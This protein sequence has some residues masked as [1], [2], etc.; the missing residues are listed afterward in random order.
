M[1]R[2]NQQRRAAKAK[3]R[4]RH[5]VPAPAY[6]GAGPGSAALPPP[7]NETEQ[8]RAETLEAIGHVATGRSAY[9]ESGIQRLVTRSREPGHA[10]VITREL[11]S[12]LRE[13]LR[14]AWM[15][16]WRPL[17][18]TR[19]V[20]RHLDA[21]HVPI[22]GDAMAGELGTYAA[23]TLAPDWPGQLRAID[24]RR[25]W[26]SD[27]DH[28]TARAAREGFEPVLRLA[29]AL[30]ALLTRLPRIEIIDPAPGTAPPPS[31]TATRGA[32][33]GEPLLERVRQLLA[34]AESTP[35]E[36][37]ADTFTTA[38]QSLMARHS[39]DAAMLAATTPHTDRPCARRVW[40]ERPYE[41]EKV[42]LLHVVAEANRCR[43]VWSS[44]L[45]FVTVVGHEVDQAAVDTLFTSLLLQG[46]RAMTHEGAASRSGAARTRGFRKSFLF[47]YAV[48]IGERLREATLA[49]TEAAMGQEAAAMAHQGAAPAPRPRGPG[50][51]GRSQAL[52]QVLSARSAEVDAAVDAMFPTTVARRSS[53]PSDLRGWEAGWRAA[54]TATLAGATERL[55]A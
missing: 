26:P 24:A 13:L 55:D 6:T 14:A 20:E 52:V 12:V 7:A 39:I 1:G 18:L 38:A 22:L 25:W 11:A 53:V 23:A 48:R 29:L 31:R 5:T 2:R 43:T 27:Q 28:V 45:G 50:G 41:R 47:S 46:T 8:V 21:R 33:A 34:K 15:A 40:I 44:G 3:E 19:H 54:E 9:A 51:S 32:P 4:R 30:A 17:D 49:E 42:R 10:R 37:E 16:G 35:Y 36:A